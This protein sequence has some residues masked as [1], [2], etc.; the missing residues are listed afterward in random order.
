MTG[1]GVG[2]YLAD[3]LVKLHGGTIAV[4]SV[5]DKGSEFIITIPKQKL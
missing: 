3:Q 5:L 1:T 2:L 4:Q